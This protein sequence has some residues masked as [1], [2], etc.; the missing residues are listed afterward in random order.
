[1]QSKADLAY[2]FIK[3]KIISGELAPLSPICEADLQKEIGASRTP[4]REAI[5]RLRDSGFIY[6]FPNNATLVSE[7]SLDLINEIYDTRFANEPFVN[8]EASKRVPSQYL[9][10]LKEKFLRAYDSVSPQ[11]HSDY[12]I[13]LD[14]KLHEGLL[15]YYPNRFIQKIMHTIFD[16]NRR[17]RRFST[18][19]NIKEHLDII[20]YL[21]IGHAPEI[22]VQESSGPGTAET[23]R[24]HHRHR[25]RLER[26]RFRI[27]YR[28]RVFPDHGR[29]HPV[30]FFQ[31][32]PR[33][34]NL[35]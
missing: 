21:P 14:D 10:D 29:V 35:D 4:V 7:I 2:D 19:I 33:R 12:L 18:Q 16:H 15:D 1:M 30:A 9:E 26:I 17:L 34:I 22:V 20:G 32:I 23:H 25:A 24:P 28:E 31:D 3:G 8:V 5:L 13:D 11:T 6:I 27:R